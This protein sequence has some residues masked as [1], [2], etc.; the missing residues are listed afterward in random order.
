MNTMIDVPEVLKGPK[1]MVQVQVPGTPP[2]DTKYS[3]EEERWWNTIPLRD[4]QVSRD[5]KRYSQSMIQGNWKDWKVGR[6][7]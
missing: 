6:G 5:G 7:S 2:I 1:T 4:R 3:E